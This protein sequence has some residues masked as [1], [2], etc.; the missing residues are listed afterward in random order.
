MAPSD[1]TAIPTTNVVFLPAE[2]TKQVTVFVNGDTGFEPNEAFTVHLSNAL[3]ATIAD[4]DGT[5][6]IT[7][8]D[9]CPTTFTVNDN[10]DAGD[11]TP[12]DGICATVGATCTLRAAIEETN[13]LSSCGTLDINLSLGSGTITLAS[14]LT[15]S[16]DV[17][18]NGP[19]ASAVII[20]GNNTNRIFTVNP[21]VTASVSSLTLSGGNGSGGGG[22]IQNSGA[23]TLS[24]VTLSGNTTTS[25]GGAIRNDGVVTLVNSTV[26]GNSANGNGG[27][28]A[29]SIAGTVTLVNST[30]TANTAGT[31][32][33]GIKSAGTLNIRN[34][35]VALNNPDN[36]SGTVNDQGNNLLSGDP[37]LG[38]LRNNGGPTFTHALLYDSPAIDAG[39]ACVVNNSCTPAYGVSLLTD[40]RGLARQVDGDL[41]AGAVVDIGAYERQVPETRVVPAGT[42]VLVDVADARLTFPSVT[43]S[44][45]TVNLSSIPVPGDAPP[46]SGPAFDISPSS[47]FFT[48][49][50]N[51]CFYLPSITNPT[52]FSTLKVLHREGGVLVDP[53]SRLSFTDKI[54]CTQVASFSEF[55]I[56]HGAIPTASNGTVGGR[57]LDN[58][59][60]PVSG[61]TVQLS[62]TQSRLTVTDSEGKY[63]FENVETN[64]FYTVTPSR[65]NYVFV[66][67]QRSFS[68]IGEHT[69]AAFSAADSGS[70][71]NPLDATVYFVRQQYLDFLG[72]EP[73]EA[74]LNFWVNNIDACGADGNCRAAKRTDTSAA[75]FLSIESQQTGY[76]VYRMYQSAF[77]EMPGAPVPLRL[78][79]FR[80]DTQTIGRGVVVNE[81]GWQAKLEANKRAFA[82]E[83][84]QRARFVSAYPTTMTPDEFVD[85][86]FLK[87]GVTPEF[88]DRAAA[89]AEFGGAGDSGDV[90]ARARALRQVAENAL[91]K[92]QQFNRAFVLMQ[93]F[94][95]LERDPNSAPD[96][97]YSGYNFWLNKLNNF[98]G[99]F[100]RA[101]MV[102]AFL[103][104]GEYRARFPR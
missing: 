104:A 9:P 95:Y 93:Y 84:V 77:G 13:A 14:E 2:T 97:D 40:Q 78:A 102:K 29:S 87:A 8:D 73:D 21:G 100:R 92:V 5:G 18:V 47:V 71:L 60:S 53:G 57:I 39:N 61:A 23:L 55:V 12:G 28:I 43:G 67:A 44:G 24:R 26:S 20:S 103:V 82:L 79:E 58:S 81:T 51:F 68:Q 85:G 54:V 56:T 99:D 31:S 17:R 27:G 16:H 80:P 33:G 49:P 70:G 66:P 30:I 45:N 86:L 7:N 63:H 65:S 89:V 76:L 41:T 42:N 74:G 15:I 22:A 52:T 19:S 3:G 94:G 72:R 35:I 90:A 91:L 25:D 83:F 48:G 96:S 88:G 98:N 10:G 62:G 11:V 75:F 34:T 50:V 1:F 64:G 6:T 46:S 59:G 69:D 37:L 38:T 32:G 36:V 101:E 4:A